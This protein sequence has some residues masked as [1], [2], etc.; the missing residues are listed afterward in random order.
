MGRMIEGE[1]RADTDV[2][3]TN[4]DG[5]FER[6]ATTFRGWIRRGDDAHPPA[7]GRYHLFVS[8]ACPWA[9]RTLLYRAL[10]GLEDAIGVSVSEPEMLESGWVFEDEPVLGVRALHEVY[11]AADPTFTGRV[12][13]PVLWDK[14]RR[15]IV[16][17]ESSEIIRMLDAA[18]GEP[19]ERFRPEAH[20]DA[21]DELNAR[22]YETLNNGVYRCG[23]ARSQGAYDRAAAELFDTLDFLEDR[24]EGRRWLVGDTLTEADLRLFPT[25]I[26]FD[27]VYFIHFK[28][29]KRRIRDYPNLWAFTRRLYQRP[30]VRATV[31][32]DHIRTHY[33]YSHESIN[34]H[35][36][37]PIAPDLGLD[38]PVD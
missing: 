8:Y 10:L 13:V 33:F 32:F 24:L 17:N 4:D 2:G 22:I 28:C 11:T 25:L 9:H 35:R 12:T 27:P 19:G 36:I 31:H 23:F 1:W 16:S 20:R 5:E 21:I 6:A 7:A 38:A 34:P 37:V 14:E 29:A 3:A 15:T 26:R 18:W 30:E